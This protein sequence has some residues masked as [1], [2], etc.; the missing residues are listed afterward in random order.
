MRI[1]Q[2]S[3]L[4]GSGLQA[5]YRVVILGLALA[6]TAWSLA[7][8][9]VDP[10][11]ARDFNTAAALQNNGL[12]EK[13][14]QKWGQFFKDHPQDKRLDK[15]Y[16]YL[17]ICQLHTQKFPEAIASFGVIAQKYPQFENS[18][19]ALFNLGMARYQ[20]ATASGKA[21]D[22]K[23]AATEFA[24]VVQ[25]FPASRHAAKSLALRGES[26]YAAGDKAGAVETYK[27][28][29]SQFPDS[30]QAA[31]AA[32]Y[33]G[34]AQQEQLQFAAA[35]ET[36]D[37]FLKKQKL[38]K[39]DLATEIRLRHG[40]CLYELKRFQEAESRFAEVALQKDYDLADFA[41]LRQGQCR[42][43]Q[44]KKVEAAQVLATLPIAFPKSG[45]KAAA[46]I[47]AG[48]CF[49]DLDKLAEALAAFKPVIGDATAKPAEQAEASY[50]SGRV[51]L[52]QSK[53]EEA[54]AMIDPAIKQFTSGEF[55][56]Y[57]AMA[58]ADAAYDI[59]ARRKESAASYSDFLTKFPQ[60]ALAPHAGYM[61]ALIALGEENFVVA[62]QQSETFLANQAN[63]ASPLRPTVLFIAA[64]SSLLGL[65]QKDAAERKKAEALYRQLVE[66]Y[67][68]HNRLPRAVLRIGWCLLEDGKPE[69]AIAY[70][71]GRVASLTDPEHK[72][73]AQ[74]LIGRSHA[75]LE[76]NPEA[77]VAFDLALAILPDSKRGDEMLSEAAG[78]LL[79][80]KNPD[81]A[82]KRL[83]LLLAKFP[84]SPLRPQ[85]TFQLAEIAR[86]KNELDPAIQRFEQVIQ[87]F[88]QSDLVPASQ[89]GLAS[90]ILA[91]GD[92]QK[93]LGVLDQLLA[94][95]GDATIKASGLFLRGAV[96]QQLQQFDGAVQDFGAFIATNPLPAQSL[97]ARYALAI[98]QIAQKNSAA[99]QATLAA[100]LAIDKNYPNADRIRYEIGHEFLAEGKAQEAREAFAT[101]VAAHPDSPLAGE[102]WFHV[103]RFHEATGEKAEAAAKGPAF[104][105][106]SKA[107]A[108]GL[109]VA[110]DPQLRE[111]LQYKLGDMRFRQQKYADA[112]TVLLAE[113]QDFPLGPLAGAAR[114]LAAESLFEQQKFL[115]ALPLFEKVASDK[116]EK[117]HARALYRAGTCAANLKNW[118]ASQA[119]FDALLRQFPTFEQV[120]DARYG[121]AFAM[122]T[123]NQ[124]DPAEKLYQ[125]VTQETEAEIAAK[126]RFMLGEIDFA[127]KKYD[128]AI[129]DFLAVSVGYP[130][131]HWQGMA[132]FETGR[133]F[134]ESG[135]K[136]KAIATL[137]TLLEKYPQH[138]R[139]ADAKRLIAELKK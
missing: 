103:G 63:D 139:V 46:E 47:A 22:W 92:A 57:L 82:A 80:L 54:I 19:G 13:A 91:K 28:T 65:G 84:G 42:I 75:K 34:V 44:G 119:H 52:K 95:K 50:W 24:L 58:R 23:S 81:G 137:E 85:A 6:L 45:L 125:Q 40:V 20:M 31:D 36:Y 93:S 8:Q 17:G 32:Y 12:Y 96:R 136:P 90:A 30:S 109:S 112:S 134:M 64:E 114:Q 107:F 70:L 41:L 55:V 7:A 73:E 43:E 89:Y 120:A 62:K 132:A 72:A 124:L 74:H 116:V 59:P 83:E 18:D 49:F 99:A 10:A 15:A 86:G 21:E 104:E 102:A 108:A 3:D 66:K 94:G 98:C 35:A 130:Y 133:C 76:R 67:P 105:E 121:L 27:Q 68:D 118:P 71:S 48:K 128:D 117:Y 138:E 37:A 38:E 29:L 135:N 122:Q 111:K 1:R 51:L 110:K 56:P 79:A 88:P 77:L 5:G 2:P 131:E 69:D 26:L 39:H 60:H 78:A 101:L 97:D 127:R 33:L 87:L 14:A 106:A 113:L 126:A 16:Y 61:S 115:D 4:V 9:E 11:A 53:P 100:I 129:E 25:K 123:Q